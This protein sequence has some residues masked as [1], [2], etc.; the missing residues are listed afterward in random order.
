VEPK[1]RLSLDSVSMI[2]VNLNRTLKDLRLNK[3]WLISKSITLA[4]EEHFSGEPIKIGVDHGLNQSVNSLSKLSA[5]AK[6]QLHHQPQNQL[7]QLQPQLLS[8]C[9]LQMSR[10]D[11]L[12]TWETGRSAQLLSNSLSIPTSLSHSLWPTRGMNR[13]TDAITSAKSQHLSQ[14]ARTNQIQTWLEPGEA[15]ERRSFFHLEE[16][17]WEAHG[18]GMSMIAGNIVSARRTMLLTNSSKLTKLN[19]LTVLI[20]ITSIMS[21][22]QSNKSSW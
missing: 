14:S 5:Q 21:K 12:H 8:Q 15:K 16:Q 17:E 22:S 9:Q 3:W 1:T 10:T 6:N 19:N 11:L 20:S 18:K 7:S 13:R 2:V 4:M